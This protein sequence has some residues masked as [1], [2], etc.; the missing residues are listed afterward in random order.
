MR[1]ALVTSCLAI[2][3]LLTHCVDAVTPTYDYRTGFLLIEGSILDQAGQSVV[4]ISRSELNFGDYRLRPVTDAVV[5]S[6]TA[7]GVE[8]R[9]RPAGPAGAYRPDSNFIT[10]PGESYY[11]RVETPVGEVVESSPELMPRPAPIAELRMTYDPESYFSAGRDR[12]VPAF[13]LTVDLD[14][15]GEEDNFYRFLHTTWSSTQICETC[16]ASVYRNGECVPRPGVDYY[17]YQCN[18]TCWSIGR[19]SEFELFSDELAPA[20]GQVRDIPAARIDHINSGGLLAEVRQE[21]VSRAAHLYYGELRDLTT[22]NA[23]LN[24]PLPAALYGNL[25]DQSERRTE[26]L[27]FVG[28]ASVSSRRLFWNRDTV[29]GEP[30]F[31]RPP[32]RPEPLMPNPPTAPCTGPDFTSQ[33]PLGWPL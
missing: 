33:R 18:T 21:S 32:I 20:G 14:D 16:F 26:V 19:S 13:T 10:T 22:G 17:D 15:P 1:P 7:G 25:T 31:I 12:F 29:P 3:L 27:G 30:L 9:W 24:A 2:C 23:G 6:V 8:V 28:V 5:V 4:R 11:L